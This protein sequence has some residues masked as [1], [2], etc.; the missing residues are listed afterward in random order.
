MKTLR[1]KKWSKQYTVRSK[2]SCK[3]VNGLINQHYRQ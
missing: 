3:V 2:Q 1:H